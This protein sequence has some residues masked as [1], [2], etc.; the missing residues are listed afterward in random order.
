MVGLQFEPQWG[1]RF[2]LS[3]QIGPEAHPASCT[4]GTDSVKQPGCGVNNPPPSRTEAKERV[5]QRAYAPQG[6]HGLLQGELYLFI[7]YECIVYSFFRVYCRSKYLNKYNI[8]VRICNNELLSW[9]E[10]IQWNNVQ[11][12]TFKMQINVLVEW[13]KSQD[14]RKEA[15]LVGLLWYLYTKTERYRPIT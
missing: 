7:F 14:T 9:S 5:E 6:L 11:N 1:S 8:I 3:V 2:S 4:V 10:N 13:S 12:I 15:S